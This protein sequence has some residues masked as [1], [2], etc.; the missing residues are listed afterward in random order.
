MT[1]VG[2]ELILSSHRFSNGL[3]LFKFGKCP[4][5][6]KGMLGKNL[7]ENVKNW[8]EKCRVKKKTIL[9]QMIHEIWI[10]HLTLC[11]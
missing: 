4:L 5:S 9:I 2:N 3:H 8:S 11:R 7:I 10:I 1:L 6:E